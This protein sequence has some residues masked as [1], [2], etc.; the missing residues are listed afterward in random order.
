MAAF[1][2]Y[3]VITCCNAFSK[4]DPATAKTVVATVVAK[5]WKGILM[6]HFFHM[7]LMVAAQ[8]LNRVSQVLL[9]GPENQYVKCLKHLSTY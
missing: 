3:F 1:W 6:M 7:I 2:Q 5:P 9:G 4:V 8:P